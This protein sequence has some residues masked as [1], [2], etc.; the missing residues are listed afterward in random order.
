MTVIVKPIG[1]CN[2]AC[3]YCFESEARRAGNGT[4]RRAFDLEKVGATIRRLHTETG[5]APVLHGGEVL[6]MPKGDLDRLLGIVGE[7]AG[8]TSLQT[9]G[10]AIDE[11]H[12]DL[13]RRHGTVVG[14][15]LDGPWPL[16]R[17]RRAGSPAQS[18]AAT[19]RIH[20]NLRALLG[21]GIP[22]G[23]IC[24][25]SRLHVEE[26]AMDALETWADALMKM[27]VTGGRFNLVHVDDPR[28][29]EE[30]ELTPAE[31]TR[32]YLRMADWSRP[33][34]EAS[35]APFGEILENLL[36]FGPS[37]CAYEDCDPHRTL[38]VLEVLAEGEVGNCAK[39]AKDRVAPIGGDGRPSDIRGRVL[40]AKPQ[41]RGGCAGCEFWSVCHGYC[42]AYAVDGD[43]RNRSRYCDTWKALYG[44]FADW[45]RKT[46]PGVRLAIDD[47]SGESPRDFNPFAEVD[48]SRFDSVS[49]PWSSRAHERAVR[50]PRLRAAV[51]TCRLFG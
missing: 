31:A 27:G 29:R 24:V 38:G 2:L 42:P 15:S 32:F 12:I 50:E 3:D 25:V 47:D 13:F 17:A 20:D 51:W 35:W 46:F 4:T 45:L 5:E 44:Y 36:G 14:L 9:N 33:H 21:A 10:L 18:E 34:P 22:V 43:W 30:Y 6:L 11:G 49:V 7:V 48:V 1:A 26:G 41:E 39:L 19:R 37:N 40:R 23:I 16:N 28:L 8:H